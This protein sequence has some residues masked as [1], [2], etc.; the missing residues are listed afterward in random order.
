M[1]CPP[2]GLICPYLS[3]GPLSLFLISFINSHTP[4]PRLCSSPCLVCPHGVSQTWTVPALLSFWA[5]LH[6]SLLAA[7]ETNQASVFL[8]PSPTAPAAWR[9]LPPGLMTLSLSSNATFSR[10]PSLTTSFIVAEIPISVC[11]PLLCYCLPWQLGLSDVVLIAWD[12]CS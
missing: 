6:T 4:L 12:V 7:P 9:A 11:Y 5:P 10:R 3:T 2:L 1:L 8:P